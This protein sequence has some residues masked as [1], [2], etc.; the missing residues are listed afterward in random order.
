MIVYLFST[1]FVSKSWNLFSFE[2]PKFLFRLYRACAY[3]CGE[4]FSKKKKGQTDPNKPPVTAE[5]AHR[6]L[7][8]MNYFQWHFIFFYESISSVSC[9]TFL[10]FYSLSGWKT[11]GSRRSILSSS[12]RTEVRWSRDQHTRTTTSLKSSRGPWRTSRISIWKI[13]WCDVWQVRIINNWFNLYF[14]NTKYWRIGSTIFEII[15]FQLIIYFPPMII[16][17]SRCDAFGEA[18]A[19]GKSFRANGPRHLHGVRTKFKFK[20][21]FF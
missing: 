7:S 9:L 14:D 4:E 19:L 20:S 18:E 17:V 11:L 10:L 16:N 3:L 12:G 5:Y 15:I 6:K 1:K 13:C 21:I 2:I 8:G